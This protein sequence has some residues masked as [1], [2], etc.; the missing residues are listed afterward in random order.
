MASALVEK[1]YVYQLFSTGSGY[2]GP[3]G[4]TSFPDGLIWLW[5]GWEYL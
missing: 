2:G 5:K 4:D 3:G 1:G